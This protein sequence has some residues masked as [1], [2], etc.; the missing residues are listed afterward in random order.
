MTSPTV[1]RQQVISVYKGPSFE[2][3]L[4]SVNWLI[5]HSELL[6]LGRDYP[7]GYP[8]FK[9]CLHSS[10]AS[11]RKLENEDDI[12]RGIERAKYVKRGTLYILHTQ[13]D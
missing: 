7:L 5:Q 6:Y 12:V 10:F 9:R 13:S 11:Q 3:S 2:Y 1:L 4:P 8:Y